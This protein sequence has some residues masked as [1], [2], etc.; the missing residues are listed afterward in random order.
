MEVRASREEKLT[1]EVKEQFA[2]ILAEVHSVVSDDVL[3]GE[4]TRLFI[5]KEEEC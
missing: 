3:V 5:T 4:D 1:Y 2:L